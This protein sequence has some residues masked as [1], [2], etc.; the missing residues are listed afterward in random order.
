MIQWLDIAVQTPAHSQVG[1]LLT[2]RHVPATEINSHLTEGVLV[3]V[4]LGSRDLLGVVWAIHNTP[5]EG[6]QETRVR[7]VAGVL[8]GLPPCPSL[9]GN[10]C[11]LPPSTTSARSVRWPWP[12]CR[13]NCAI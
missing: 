12:L 6:L 7:D 8:E 1:G 13:P 4:P 10:W 9:G 3:R 2:Y 11:N 5:P